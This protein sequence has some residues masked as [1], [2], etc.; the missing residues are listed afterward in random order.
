MKKNLLLATALLCASSSLARAQ[1]DF[2]HGTWGPNSGVTQVA[3]SGVP[4]PGFQGVGFVP[5]GPRIALAAIRQNTGLPLLA[6]DGAGTYT[7]TNGLNAAFPG[8]PTWSIQFYVGVT[9]QDLFDIYFA[10]DYNPGVNT[11]IDDMGIVGYHPGCGAGCGTYSKN[12]Y[13]GFPPLS[14]I[15]DPV[16]TTPVGSFNPFALGEYTFVVAAFAHGSSVDVSPL[17]YVS[18]KVNVV[19]A[20]PEPSTY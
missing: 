3:W 11:P 12:Y 10:Y 18:I 20:V 14:S 9:N 19:S 1:I 8:L 15:A 7:A 5:N 16:L 13:M 17:E 4:I 6:N 2:P